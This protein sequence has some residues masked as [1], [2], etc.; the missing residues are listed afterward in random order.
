MPNKHDCYA[1]LQQVVVARDRLCRAPGCCGLATA[2]HHIF[3]RDRLATAFL[4]KYAIGLCINCHIPWAHKEPD[5]FTE[6]VISWMSE[7]EYYA[8]LRLSHTAVK[9]LDY[10]AI[11]Q[12]LREELKKQ[13]G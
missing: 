3:K 9:F 13:T 5:Q 2:G 1:L 4:P 12:S 6:W 11:Y 7:E 10:D 8:G